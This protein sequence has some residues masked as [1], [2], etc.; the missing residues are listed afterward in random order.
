[1]VDFS[2]R[3]E[4][5]IKTRS[6]QALSGVIPP[7][8]SLTVDV[9]PRRLQHFRFAPGQTLEWEVKRMSDG[10]TIQDNL[11][12]VDANGHATAE[13]VIVYGTGSRLRIKA[14]G[15]A[16]VGD[17]QRLRPMLTLDRAPVVGR[18]MV[19]ATW[20][21][22]GDASL[23]LFDVSGR[24]LRTLQQGPARGLVRYEVD[25]GGLSPGIYF[26]RARQDGRSTT[27][28]FALLH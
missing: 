22:S 15:P 28:R 24:R 23:A 9:T 11:I 3:W 20:P 5:M 21:G 8:E 27:L 2:D 12:Q 18:T 4:V 16:G 26:L 14:L 7:P 19:S 10:L 13:G 1:M 6:V 25:G 17:R